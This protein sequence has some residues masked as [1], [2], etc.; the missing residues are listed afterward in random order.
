MILLLV[1][2]VVS[3]ATGL[4]LVLRGS[5]GP[6][7]RSSARFAEI[8]AYGFSGGAKV[9]TQSPSRPLLSLA[10]SLGRIAQRLLG[11]GEQGIR[12]QLLAAGMYNV[13]P[14]TVVGFRVLG[15]IGLASFWVWFGVS[16]GFSGAALLI[17]T[18]ALGGLGWML[19]VVIL[20]RRGRRRT[21]QI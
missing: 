20:S 7:G 6:S 8:E 2:G 4:M 9:E 21:E 1:I 12:R 16:G 18:V 10:N 5:T 14:T 17:G 19:P 3:L 13:D 15:A 11:T